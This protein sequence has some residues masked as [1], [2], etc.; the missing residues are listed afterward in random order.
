[1]KG[2]ASGRGTFVT[3][4]RPLT[5]SVGESKADLPDARPDFSF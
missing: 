1:M 2:F 5:K 3:C 4:R